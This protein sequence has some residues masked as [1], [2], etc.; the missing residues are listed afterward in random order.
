MKK[1]ILA[2][3]SPRRKEIL[4]KYLNDYEIITSDI[5]EIHGEDPFTTVAA[6]S[7]E[8]C[9]DVVDKIEEGIVISADTIVYKDEILGK[10]KDADDAF[11]MLQSLRNTYHYVYTG[12]CIIEKHTLKK[13]VEVVKTKVVMKDY[14]DDDIRKYIESGEPFGK[15]GAYA[16]QGLGGLLVEC[17][18]GDYLNI[19]GLP[20]TK[21]YE[22]LK[23]FGINLL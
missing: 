11:K 3:G 21:L 13:R 19:V 20:I 1:I 12:M 16:I 5:V 23:E 22:M 15:A 9:I 2:S 6:L 10:P 17:I 4:S 8:K 14:S 7:F 18:E